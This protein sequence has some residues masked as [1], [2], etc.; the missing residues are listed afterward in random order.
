MSPDP[1]AGPRVLLRADAGPQLGHGHVARMRSLAE[2]FVDRGASVCLV[3]EGSPPADATWS[4]SPLGT[5]V[6]TSG[7]SGGESTPTEQRAD[8]ERTFER[9]E[10]EPDL[11]VVDSY[12][13]GRVWEEAVRRLAPRVRLAAIDDLV[14]RSHDVDVLVDPNLGDDGPVNA[15]GPGR[16][17][18]Q[19]AAYAP[20][21]R[22]YEAALQRP[23]AADTREHVVMNLGGG[24]HALVPDLARRLLTDPRLAHVALTF[25]V[26]DP[27]HHAAVRQ[28]AGGRSDV[29]VHARLTSLRPLLER[30]TLAI[31]AG[32]TSSWER[33]RLGVPSVVFALADNQRRTCEGLRD[34]GLAEWVEHPR[35]PETIVDAT[36]RALADE[37][38]R[39]RVRRVG[40]LLVDGLGARR[41]ALATL[42]PSGSPVLRS[43]AED[44]AAVLFAIA[45]DAET[46]SMSRGTDRVEP[47]EHLAWFSRCRERDGATFW[48]AE[49]H[50]LPVG[51]IRL[52][53]SGSSWE[54]SYALEAAARGMG[55]ATAIVREGVRR[56][57]ETDQGTVIAVVRADNIASHRVFRR[58]GFDHDADG[59]AARGLGASVEPGF[60]AYLL[61]PGRPTA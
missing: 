33:L 61:G 19:G 16:R 47:D 31:G 9:F 24:S 58:L 49:V 40:P 25:V 23:D 13:L 48:I 37:A 26:P 32:G 29:S 11:V 36:V 5:P 59:A 38:L 56:L 51:Q 22:D 21:G 2:A 20:L 60:S 10:E 43:V 44:D 45:N 8:A 52:H 17:T 15:D 3:G 30:A 12:R 54:V 42:S 4:T 55:W 46:R 35:T 28:A 39:T 27:E 34:R 41:I 53:R 7:G 1:S 50:G 6:S 14:T 57:R 18:L